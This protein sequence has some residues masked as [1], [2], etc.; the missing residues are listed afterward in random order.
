MEMKENNLSARTWRGRMS[1]AMGSRWPGVRPGQEEPDPTGSPG[2]TAQLRARTDL[3]RSTGRAETK[4]KTFPSSPERQI[5][6]VSSPETSIHTNS[7]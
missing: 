7:E 1:K 5:Y 6:C 2:T 4:R 3:T